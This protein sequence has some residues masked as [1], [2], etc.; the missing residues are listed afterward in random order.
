L[1]GRS[2]RAR[3]ARLVLKEPWNGDPPQPALQCKAHLS[4][5][6]I[7]QGMRR[8]KSFTSCY[9]RTRTN[10][11]FDLDNLRLL[12]HGRVSKVHSK[13]LEISI[14]RLLSCTIQLASTSTS[15]QAQRCARAPSAGK[16]QPPQLEGTKHAPEDDGRLQNS[17]LA[18]TQG[19]AQPSSDKF[20]R[21][22]YSH[23]SFKS[24]PYS[25]S[26][27]PLSI[28]LPSKDITI[29]GSQSQRYSK[30]RCRTSSNIHRLGLRELKHQEG[31]LVA[32]WSGPSPL[33]IGSSQRAHQTKPVTSIG[34]SRTT[35]LH[36]YHTHCVT[37][38][39]NRPRP[40]TNSP[41]AAVSGI[42]R[43]DGDR[44]QVPYLGRRLTPLRLNLH[45]RSLFW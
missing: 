15:R 34:F 19:K 16:W 31:R 11:A 21:P 6:K 12:S 24:N 35:A 2:C 38:P 28:S 26:S 27:Y 37:E 5:L 44:W 29:P 18:S 1:W 25:L 13:L 41:A 33:H 36:Q 20:S 17:R 14:P 39:H 3:R 10:K 43:S 7:G 45:C 22:F 8:R 40:T 32:H 30:T 9:P 42:L 23:Y 4:F